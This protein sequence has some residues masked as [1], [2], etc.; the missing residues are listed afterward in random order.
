MPVFL[1]CD[2]A[3]VS[4]S[5]FLF[6][7]MVYRGECK[8]YKLKKVKIPDTVTY[9]YSNAFSGCKNIIIYAQKGSYV[10]KLRHEIIK[11][12]NGN[13]N[14]SDAKITDYNITGMECYQ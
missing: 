2:W 11:N 8:M 7:Q 10:L 14:N 3:C 12:K 4:M 5:L 13:R 1:F 6:Q 9:I